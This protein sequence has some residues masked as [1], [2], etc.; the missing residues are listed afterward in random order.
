MS[1]NA[2]RFQLVLTTAGSEEQAQTIARELVQRRLAACVSI[3][4]QVCSVYMWKGELT[5]EDEKLLII[6]S[7]AA[8]FSRLSEAIHELFYEIVA[9]HGTTVVVVTH[10]PSF[11]QRMPRVIEMRDGRVVGDGPGSEHEAAAA[12]DAQPTV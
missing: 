3:V 6:K 7:D 12:G 9:T 4:N 8:S 10:N 5:E 11:A 2:E 1:A